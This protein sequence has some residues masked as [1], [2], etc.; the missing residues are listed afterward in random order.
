VPRSLLRRFAARP[1]TD[2]SGT[3]TRGGHEEDEKAGGGQEGA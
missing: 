3:Q 1:A 2:A